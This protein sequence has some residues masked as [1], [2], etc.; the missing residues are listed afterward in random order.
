MSTE[1]TAGTMAPA[2]NRFT[3]RSTYVNVDAYKPLLREYCEKMVEKKVF[4]R[5]DS[6]HVIGKYRGNTY[7]LP[8]G[9]WIKL[10]RLPNARDGKPLSYIEINPQTKAVT[11]NSDGKNKAGD[12][13]DLIATVKRVDRYNPDGWRACRIE[14]VNE[15]GDY[16]GKQINTTDDKVNASAIKKAN[17]KDNLTEDQIKEEDRIRRYVLKDMSQ[18][19][20]DQIQNDGT[21]F[22]R[23]PMEVPVILQSKQIAYFAQ[24]KKWK[25]E[26]FV[27]RIPDHLEPAKLKV[28]VDHDKVTHKQLEGSQMTGMMYVAAMLDGNKDKR[29]MELE[30]MLNGTRNSKNGVRPGRSKSPLSPNWTYGKDFGFKNVY[31][32]DK[33]KP[34]V[35][36]PK[37]AI[38]EKISKRTKKPYQIFSLE[39]PISAD[40]NHQILNAVWIDHAPHDHLIQKP[41]VNVSKI[42]LRPLNTDPNDHSMDDSII[43]STVG[44]PSTPEGKVAYMNR[45]A[46]N[47]INLYGNCIQ[48]VDAFRKDP[49]GEMRKI[50]EMGTKLNGGNASRD[51]TE[52]DKIKNWGMRAFQRELTLDYVMRTCGYY[53][54]ITIPERDRGAICRWLS[55]DFTNAKD[56]PGKRLI[57]ASVAMDM[58]NKALRGKSTQ[59]KAIVNEEIKTRPKFQNVSMALQSDYTMNDGTLLPK[60]TGSPEFFWTKPLTGETAYKLLNDICYKDKALYGNPDKEG[61]N[62]LVR[63]D[64]KIGDKEYKN[65]TLTLGK[66]ETGNEPTVAESLLNVLK[67]KQ[68]ESAYVKDTINKEFSGLEVAKKTAFIKDEYKDMKKEDFMAMV[69]AKFDKMDESLQKN[70]SGFKIDET[71]Y[72]E[73]MR[74]DGK[75]M[76]YD[77]AKLDADVYRYEV[78][79]QNTTLLYEA[80]GKSNVVNI[81]PPDPK[82]A[83]FMDSLV[84]E[85][86]RPLEPVKEIVDGKLENVKNQLGQET[87][88]DLT[89][90]THTRATISLKPVPYRKGDEWEKHA[91][92]DKKFSLEYTEN[93]EVQK[94]TGEEARNKL[95]VTSMADKI[96]FERE[97]E[98]FRS[99]ENYEKVNV[100]VKWGDEVIFEKND[101]IG[102]KAFSNVHSIE[103]LLSSQ[104]KGLSAQG[105]AALDE[106][107]VLDKGEEKYSPNRDINQSLANENKVLKEKDIQ[108]V[109]DAPKKVAEYE[110]P[111]NR[112]GT[113]KIDRLETEALINFKETEQDVVDHIVDGL[114]KDSEAKTPEALKQIEETFKKERPD[115]VESLKASLERKEVKKEMGISTA[116]GLKRKASSNDLKI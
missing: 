10:D 38:E 93:G 104:R 111:E 74:I 66:L 103:E 95:L 81:Q 110:I 60:G 42:S 18:K 43:P 86:R 28:S 1:N 82:K 92:F 34:L 70:L 107:L 112:E 116:K 2:T 14:A 24:G 19:I 75:K 12:V 45:V 100:V 23:E 76:D 31:G 41:Y 96:N 52:N 5:V 15:L 22:G 13:F 16:V 4:E 71:N 29:Y 6:D 32:T 59:E 21:L 47:A 73:A 20:M 109:L 7:Q 37:I 35:E 67:K 65:V 62:K 78:P 106:L 54:G 48:D 58:N 77:C 39:D 46:N 98:G 80:F 102:S 72:K 55:D 108:K 25:K 69:K 114:I 36:A 27:D 63:F 85:L 79:S 84:V 115:M 94:F 26:D 8:N 113:T 30:D 83:L 105:K 3:R 49:I 99:V 51:T 97:K 44:T 87:F 91:E 61:Y 88:A 17:Q 33:T 89:T 101:R 11:K 90:T 64:L 56:P 53:G 9:R 40:V 68:R 50:I 57:E